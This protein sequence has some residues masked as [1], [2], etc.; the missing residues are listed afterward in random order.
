MKLLLENWRKFVKQEVEKLLPHG[1]VRAVKKIGSSTLSP[2]EQA[3]QDLEKYGYV[4]DEEDRDFD[5]EVQI[6][7]VSNEDVEEWAFSEKAAE[8]EDFYNYDVQLRIVENWRK[9]INEVTTLDPEVKQGLKKAIVDSNFWNLPHEEYDVVDST[10]LKMAD[11]SYAG[12]TPASVALAKHLNDTAQELG[13]DLLFV[14]TVEKDDGYVL[15]DGDANYP[16]NWLMGGEFNGPN[17]ASGKNLIIIKLRPLEEDFELSNVNFIPKLLIN[18]ISQ[19]VNHEMVHY[20]QMKK[21]AK[22]KG[23]SDEEAWEE[24]LCDP[25]QI[26]LGASQEDRDEWEQR[27]GRAP[28]KDHHGKEVYVTRHGEIDAYAHEAAEQLLTYMSPEAVIRH[29]RT[30]KG[31]RWAAQQSLAVRL[32]MDTLA[33]DSK[34]IKKFWTKLYTQIQQQSQELSEDSDFQTNMKKKLPNELDFLLNKG[35]NNTKVGKGIKNPKNPK[36]DSKPPGA[37]GG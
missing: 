36:F 33:R 15:R 23:L 30:S 10:S 3:E 19:V 14:V 24:L 16:N 11:G 21:Q 26:P 5:I 17:P 1:E 7:G 20:W 9:H 27:C 37:S 31:I 2:E 8:L 32:F 25:E 35:G 18:L 12:E 29:L 4:R 28:P 6:A 22:S 13:T 34:E